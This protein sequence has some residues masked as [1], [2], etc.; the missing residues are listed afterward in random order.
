MR[1]RTLLRIVQD[2]LL[3]PSYRAATAGARR[4]T[5]SEAAL[6]GRPVD[7]LR[8]VEASRGGRLAD[9]FHGSR[10][11]V[12]DVGEG[13]LPLEEGRDGDLVGRVEDRRHPSPGL[14]GLAGQ[15]EGRVAAR[16]ELEEIEA[17]ERRQ[18]EAPEVVGEPLGVAQRVHDRE[19]HVVSRQLRHERPVDELDEGVDERL[20][21]D[22][23][24]DSLARQSEQEVRLDHLEALVHHRRRIDRDLRAH[25]PGG[26]GE[27]VLDRDR[28]ERVQ[29]P[30][31]EGAARRPSGRG[32]A[33]PRAG[34]NAS[35]GGSRCA[36]NRPARARRRSS[37]PRPG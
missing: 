1:A 14:Q 5:I 36:R 8:L 6:A 4:R 12:N 33:P 28:V 18:V 30:L 25:L 27:R 13:N 11:D 10:N 24:V 16:V 31:A 20:G 21:M 29:A 23:D 15:A 35:P 2:G 32:A 17:R 22:H 3:E 26:V 19:L 34:R 9:A 37:S 7:R